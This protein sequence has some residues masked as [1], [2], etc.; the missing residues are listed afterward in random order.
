MILISINLYNGNLN[1]A[2]IIFRMEFLFSGTG[3]IKVNFYKL[4]KNNKKI[5]NCIKY[6]NIEK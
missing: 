5:K 3:V 1:G 4:F 6:L 2:F